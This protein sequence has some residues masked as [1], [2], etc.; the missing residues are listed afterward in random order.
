MYLVV[1]GWLYV[2]VMMSVA[3]A[4]HP[5]GTVLGAVVT[6]VL[7]GLAPAG[8]AAYLMGTPLRNKARKAREAADLPLAQARALAAMA[9]AQGSVQPDTGGHAPGGA[10]QKG[11]APVRKP[12]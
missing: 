9:E 2:A 7:Y 12:D 1:I 5:D 6:F 8:L 4:M 3:E 10:Q 11:I